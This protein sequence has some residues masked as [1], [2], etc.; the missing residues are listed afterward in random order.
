MRTIALVLLFGLF[1]PVS[2]V[3]SASDQPDLVPVKPVRITAYRQLTG[4][5]WSNS[6][7]SRTAPRYNGAPAAGQQR[8][9][10]GALQN[11]GGAMLDGAQSGIE[12]TGRRLG[13]AGQNLGNAVDELSGGAIG[14][15]NDGIRQSFDNAT[16]AARNTGD[17][18]T[19]QPAGNQPAYNPA[20]H[21]HPAATNTQLA[22][23]SAH[24]HPTSVH[25]PQ[26]QTNR[27]QLTQT[28]IQTGIQT[29]AQTGTQTRAQNG[30]YSAPPRAGTN[31]ARTNNQSGRLNDPGQSPFLGNNGP[32]NNSRSGLNF[33]SDQN[34]HAGHDHSGH[35]HAG[36]SHAQQQPNTQTRPVQTADTWHGSNTGQNRSNDMV[37]VTPVEN[38]AFRTNNF[39]ANNQNTAGRQ[40]NPNPPF[41][42]NSNTSSSGSPWF[43]GGNSATINSQTSTNAN[44]YNYDYSRN[45]GIAAGTPQ[46]NNA[47]QDH[48]PR[49]TNYASQSNSRGNV[50]LSSNPYARLNNN[51]SASNTQTL[52]PESKWLPL[53]MTGVA[54]MGSIGANLFLGFG[55][56]DARHKYLSTI[57][58][59]SRSFARIDE[60]RAA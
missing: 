8:S 14:R 2:A 46:N 41:A 23:Q 25:Q 22:T 48:R 18:W 52:A 12:E 11:V 9:V 7:S 39:P 13:N 43:R 47:S 36:N 28:G 40:T 34:N 45:T 33:P 27:S 44:G 15:M 24:Q 21:N 59:G 5:D 31:T 30:G 60:S 51:Q 56:L 55:Y 4:N 16:Q 58:R 32:G 57:R 1:N 37:N 42:T 49:A 20:A 50:P 3:D 10:A 26:L 35:D 53:M 54:L 19:N 6:V 29:G 38:G 17:G